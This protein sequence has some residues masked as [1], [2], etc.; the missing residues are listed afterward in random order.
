V[1]KIITGFALL[2]SIMF[3]SSCEKDKGMLPNISFKTGAVYISKDTTLA[4]GSDFVIGINA[5]KAETVDVLK[6]FNLSKS[7]NGG[8]QQTEFSKAL[9]GTEGDSYSYEYLGTT[10]NSPGQVNK[11]TFTITNRDGLTNQIS[12]SITIQ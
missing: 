11:Y 4:A 3:I 7:V 5:S 2:L 12:V 9:T 1:K 10:E 8:A 6:Q